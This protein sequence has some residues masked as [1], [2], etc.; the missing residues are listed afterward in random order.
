MAPGILP[1]GV[2]LLIPSLVPGSN[3]PGGSLAG[4]DGGGSSP[5][6]GSRAGPG[7]RS[8]EGVAGVRRDDAALPLG[9]GTFKK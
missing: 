5:L 1:E 7:L 9:K 4:A 2:R 6:G 8:A 3:N